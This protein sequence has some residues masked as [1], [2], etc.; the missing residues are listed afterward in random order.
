ME[1]AELPHR[2]FKQDITWW[3]RE[4]KKGICLNCGQ[5]YLSLLLREQAAWDIYETADAWEV[6]KATS[7]RSAV[8]FSQGSESTGS[9]DV[10]FTSITKPW[11]SVGNVRDTALTMTLYLVL[12]SS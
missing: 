5:V 9:L 8:G 7:S 1:L 3:G 11:L 6:E 2:I 4:E 10:S 12:Q